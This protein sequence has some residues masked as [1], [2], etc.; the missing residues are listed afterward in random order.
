VTKVDSSY[1]DTDNEF[2]ADYVV[3]GWQ[4]LQAHRQLGWKILGPLVALLLVRPN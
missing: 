3:A 1:L 2:P 4:V